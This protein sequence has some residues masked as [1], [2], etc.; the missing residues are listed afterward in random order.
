MLS[1]YTNLEVA[2]GGEYIEFSG[3]VS[4]QERATQSLHELP[5]CFYVLQYVGQQCCLRSARYIRYDN[6]NDF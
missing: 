5:S 1:A 2:D 3:G 6:C 4:I